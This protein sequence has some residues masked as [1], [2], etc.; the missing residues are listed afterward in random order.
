MKLTVG[1]G[2]L[3][4]LLAVAMVCLLVLGWAAATTSAPRTAAALPPVMSVPETDSTTTAE[5]PAAVVPPSKAPLAAQRP[6]QNTP[7]PARPTVPGQP[8]RVRLERLGLDASILPAARPADGVFNPPGVSYAYWMEDYGTAGPRAQN[9]NYVVAHS[10]GNGF[11]VFNPL[12]DMPSES[13]AATAGDEIKVTTEQG[14][15]Q[16]AVTSTAIYEQNNVSQ[17]AELWKNE[18]GRL[19][20]ITCFQNSETL[21]S[22]KNYVVYA[23]LQGRGAPQ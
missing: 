9:T 1:R 16:Y 6:Q 5:G 19:V 2:L 8:T 21:F 18:P 4:A 10:S 3:I 11:A 22:G 20:L 23:E 13:G 17:E 14:T 12:L 7:E 15:Y